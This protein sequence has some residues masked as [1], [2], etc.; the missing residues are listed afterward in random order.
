MLREGEEILTYF[1]AIIS[2]SKMA[3]ETPESKKQKKMFIVLAFVAVAI[4]LVLYFGFRSSGIPSGDTVSVGAGPGMLPGGGS[5][6]L[7]GGGVLPSENVN[8]IISLNK[9]QLNFGV[10]ADSIFQSLKDF[11]TF[12]DIPGEKGRPNPFL[13]Y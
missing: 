2:S 12:A 4:I 5:Q 13:P 3:I 11:E 10:L 7:P 9:I 6:T 8:A 1:M